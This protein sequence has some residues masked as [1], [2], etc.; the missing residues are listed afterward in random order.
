[1]SEIIEKFLKVIASLGGVIFGTPEFK[2]IKIILSF[3]SIIISILLIWYWIY[4]ERKYKYGLW[5]WKRVYKDFTE[6]FIKSDYFRKKWVDIKKVYLSNYMKSLENAYLF[7]SELIDF[8]GYEGDNIIE[9]Y[10]KFPNQILKNKDDFLK[11]LEIL[12]LIYEKNKKKQKIE[13]SQKETIKVLYV[14]EKGLR[15]LL[16]INQGDL[17]VEELIP[18]LER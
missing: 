8:Y 16:V 15:N 14:I 4:L 1:M 7:L 9:K 12:V 11:A 10:Q 17:W 6:A 2:K 13:I 5:E 3:F 18:P